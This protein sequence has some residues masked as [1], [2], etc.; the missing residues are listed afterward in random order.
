MRLSPVALALATLFAVKPEIV[1]PVE[2][3]V[4]MLPL[5]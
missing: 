5:P 2:R 4:I 1:V 3:P